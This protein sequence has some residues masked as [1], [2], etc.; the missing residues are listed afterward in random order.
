MTFPDRPLEIMSQVTTNIDRLKIKTL[1][2]CGLSFAILTILANVPVGFGT[3]PTTIVS[4]FIEYLKVAT[5]PRGWTVIWASPEK[6]SGVY[7]VASAVL[8][9]ILAYPILSRMIVQAMAVRIPVSNRSSMIL[10]A[11]ASAL[12][13]IG[14]VFGVRIVFRYMFPLLVPFYA[15][16]NIA[17]FVDAFDYYCMLLG[18]ILGSGLAFSIPFYVVAESIVR[19]RSKQ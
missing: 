1:Q 15:M 5:L 7:V 16:V 19:C 12:F 11:T 13:Y 18:V 8:V 3:S 17:T 2:T 9:L 14:A 4:S 6:E 10:V